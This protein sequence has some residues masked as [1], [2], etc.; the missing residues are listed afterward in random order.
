MA[1]EW[2]V[3]RKRLAKRCKDVLETNGLR[4]GTKTGNK[5]IHTFFLG[6]LVALDL[7]GQPWVTICLLSGRHDDL[8]KED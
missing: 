6:A 5:M 4:V 3:T 8:L 1:E 2:N 7:E